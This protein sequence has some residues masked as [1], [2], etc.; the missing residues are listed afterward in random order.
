MLFTGGICAV[1]GTSH[2]LRF[3]AVFQDV[4]FNTYVF[5]VYYCH[6]NPDY[7]WHPQ[8]PLFAWLIKRANLSLA[9]SCF[10]WDE[11]VKCSQ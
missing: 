2:V 5:T 8:M 6:D 4:P 7:L 10:I 3:C 1:N 11:A 9:F